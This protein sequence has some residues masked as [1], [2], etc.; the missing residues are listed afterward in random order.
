MILFQ[1]RNVYKA[2]LHCHST[3][4]DGKHTPEELKQMYMEKG[5]HILAYTDHT[6]FVQHNDLTDDRFLAINAVE[7]DRGQTEG[8]CKNPRARK[9]WHIN[10]YALTHDN[11]KAPPAPDF[12]YYDFDALNNYIAK[13][14][15][16]GFIACYNHP[17]WSLQTYEDYSQIKHC[18]AM[19]IYNHNCE[20]E[21]GGRG[22][23]AQAYDD[24]LRL[25]Q[26][27]YCL[28]TDDNHNWAE[29]DAYAY[30][31]FGGW[32]NINS[33]DLTYESVMKALVQG[34]FYASQGPEIKTIFLND[35]ELSVQCS[36]ASLIRVYTDGRKCYDAAGSDL[37]EATFT[38]TGKEQYI[39]I[40]V[41]DKNHKDANSNA[42]WL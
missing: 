21:D 22:Y 14:R 36:G 32:V 28:S 27:I 31:A 1:A 2:N 39:R 30:D 16:E 23:H 17:Y 42:Y 3:I 41:R 9:T 40:M 33:H 18:F 6:Q 38:L 19:E 15:E 29:P 8:E 24:M 10:F 12:G 5:Y 11:D 25:G 26:K 7:I 4:S 35:H 13:R 37:T 34:D 20:V